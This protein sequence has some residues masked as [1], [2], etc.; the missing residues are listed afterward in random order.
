MNN[1]GAPDGV[2]I[3]EWISRQD[4]DVEKA[5][6]WPQEHQISENL[7]EEG[8]VDRVVDLTPRGTTYF[9]D[10][11]E[12]ISVVSTTSHGYT[13]GDFDFEYGWA[14]AD[15]RINA[16]EPQIEPETNL[17]QY[18]YADS[19]ERD[20]TLE[21][22]FSRITD[23]TD[24]LLKES[25]STVLYSMAG[26]NRYQLPDLGDSLDNQFRYAERISRQLEELGFDTEII[27]EPEESKDVYLFG[28]R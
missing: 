23:T 27:H 15:D 3:G 8:D 26:A 16:L 21:R 17:H 13:G 5:V 2:R 18:E 28:Q 7:V 11:Q 12:Q 22:A 24:R 10:H 6:L 20:L 25:D 14:V 4:L 9:G 1:H 19:E